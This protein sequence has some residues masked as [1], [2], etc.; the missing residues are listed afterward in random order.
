MAKLTL[1]ANWKNHPGSLS[2]AK[3]LLRQLSANKALYRNL[4]LFIAPPLS[5]FESVS[6]KS[7]NYANLASQDI[8]LVTKTTTGD[9]TPD[10]LKSFGTR[11]A[12]IGHSERR[13]LGETSAEVS[14]KVKVAMSSG[15][16]PLVC[17][18]EKERDND[19]EHFEFLREQLK[20]SLAGFSRRGDA[21]KIILAYEPVW[22]IGKNANAALSPGDLSQ[23]VIFIKKVLSD[24][25][26]RSV[27]EKIPILYGGSV[28]PANVGGLVSGTG[29]R[30]FLVGHSS[31]NAKSFKIIAE[32][33]LAKK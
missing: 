13:A 29:I 19:G 17:I 7:R 6:D 15:L 31:L 8:T 32:A 25:F 18:G 21:S 11:L 22:A 14:R 2:E 33:L 23:T 10:I 5:Y 16:T 27:A 9:I 26:G 24:M 4:S 20:S 1:V 28:E 12:I 30:G 3:T